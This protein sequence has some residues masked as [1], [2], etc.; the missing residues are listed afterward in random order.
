MPRS[1][2]H[3]AEWSART[4]KAA[5]EAGIFQF[6][7]IGDWSAFSVPPAVTSGAALASGEAFA[8]GEGVCAGATPRLPGATTD[9][10]VSAS[11]V[12]ALPGTDAG[13]ESGG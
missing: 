4:T 5:Q 10:L 3:S 9:G 11:G 6:L 13:E 12:T 2:M 8:A 1:S 7:S